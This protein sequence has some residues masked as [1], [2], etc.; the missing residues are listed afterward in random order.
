MPALDRFRLDGCAA[1][2]TGASSGIGARAAQCLAAA[3]ASVLAVARRAD[4]LDALAAEIDGV[5]AAPADLREPAA[6]TSIVA[7][8]AERFGRLDVVV[9]AAGIDDVMPAMREPIERFASVLDLNV[10]AAFAVAQAAVGEM[11]AN[12]GGS[13]VNVSSVL[14]RISEP[15]VPAAAYVASKGAVSAM[16]R[17]LAV[18]W[19]R[20]GVRVNDLVPGWFPTEM[21]AALTDDEARAGVFTARR[22]PLGRFGALE[23][24]DGPLLLLASAAGSYITG[25]AIVVD[26]GATAI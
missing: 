7:T 18:Q 14:G 10:V 4:R 17:E 2:V 25:Q 24:L 11:R 12:G 19:A 21:T 13:I 15:S 23:E 16:T 22:V 26:G 6:A 5:V 20:Y 3:G 1:V 9:N 8:A